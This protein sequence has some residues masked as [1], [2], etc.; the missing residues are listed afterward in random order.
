MTPVTEHF[1][2]EE[3][4]KKPVDD[5]SPEVFYLLKCLC[6]NIL[7]PI[8]K[9]L[10]GTPIKINSGIR[11]NSD[12][13]RLL[14]QGYFPSETSDHFFGIP[15]Q[16]RDPSKMKLYGDMYTLSTGAIDFTHSM[17]VENAFNKL[18]REANPQEGYLKLNG[19]KIQ[20]GQ[21]ILETGRHSGWIH[22]S[23]PPGVKFN[24][25]FYYK[26]KRRSSTFLFS[27]D[28]GKTYQAI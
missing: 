1:S 25:D 27:R 20:I 26:V 23:N 4:S 14:E 12:H 8:R 17:G 16:L 2:W 3:F 9:F 24:K 18:L 21:M 10:G 22:V 6:Q 5:F 15:V 11:G 7:E 28:S 19:I 13:Y